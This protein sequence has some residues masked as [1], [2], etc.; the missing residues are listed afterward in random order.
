[1]INAKKQ[2]NYQV[3]S[4]GPDGQELLATFTNRSNLKYL[5]SLGQSLVEISKVVPDGLLIFFPSYAWMDT[6]LSHWKQTGVW[7]RLNNWKQCFVEPKNR[8]LLSKTVSEFRA[9]VRHVSRI[10]ACFLAVCRGKV[11]EGIDFADADA[12]AVVITGIPFP[13]V[14]D[15]KY[16]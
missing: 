16:H 8:S 1:M 5:S 9:K 11:S 4:S 12:R 14:Y 3:I 6:C 10:G 15:P 2:I 7:E 13:S